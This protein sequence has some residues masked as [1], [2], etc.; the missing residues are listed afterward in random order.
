MGGIRGGGCL[1]SQRQA[2]LLAEMGGVT[3][4][5]SSEQLLVGGKS[6]QLENMSEDGGF[7]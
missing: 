5:D 1:R 7:A 3:I 6:N 4:V 2:R